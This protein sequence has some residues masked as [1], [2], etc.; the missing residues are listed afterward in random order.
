MF[1][2]RISL[3]FLVAPTRNYPTNA[4]WDDTKTITLIIDSGE[5]EDIQGRVDEL[6]GKNNSEIFQINHCSGI[7]Q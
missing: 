3:S 6:T 4:L 7:I 1:N 2:F 5:A